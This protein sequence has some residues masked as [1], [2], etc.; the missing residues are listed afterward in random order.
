MEGARALFILAFS[1]QL[2][3][4]ELCCY[5]NFFFFFF[6]DKNMKTL[7]AANK[8]NNSIKA[9]NELNKR[10]LLIVADSAAAVL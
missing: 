4:A 2:R 6:V 10:N 9:L 3:A 1:A 5:G 7:K 8:R